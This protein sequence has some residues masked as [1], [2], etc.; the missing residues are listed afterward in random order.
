MGKTRNYVYTKDEYLAFLR[1]SRGISPKT[2][3]SLF[4]WSFLHG[5]NIKNMANLPL[6]YGSKHHPPTGMGPVDP[7][8]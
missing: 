3:E 5:Q 2:R 7:L 1:E 4:F 8:Q 6:S